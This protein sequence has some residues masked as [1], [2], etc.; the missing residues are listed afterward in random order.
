M[1]WRIDARMF[2]CGVVQGGHGRRFVTQRSEWTVGG[3]G[4]H[5][6]RDGSGMASLVF[7]LGPAIANFSCGFVAWD[8]GEASVVSARRLVGDGR[9][10]NGYDVFY[11]TA[12]PFLL[13]F[14][15]SFPSRARVRGGGSGQS[16]KDHF[17]F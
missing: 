10:L 2:C 1:G 3:H 8:M 12:F 9:C 17:V 4:V 11:E 13:I 6:G 5:G 7:D 16:E 15:Y 14:K